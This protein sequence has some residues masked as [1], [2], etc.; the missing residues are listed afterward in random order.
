MKTKDVMAHFGNN[1]KNVCRLL[2]LSPAWVNHWGEIV[3]EVCAW[4]LDHI[5]RGKLKIDPALYDRLGG[6]KPM[7]YAVV[8]RMA[9]TGGRI[10]L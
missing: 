1:Q 4:R 8:R 5:T 3:P 6:R 10:R 7:P 2:G 9:R